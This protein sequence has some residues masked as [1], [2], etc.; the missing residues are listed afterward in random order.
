MATAQDTV[1]GEALKRYRLAAGL[2]QEELAERSQMSVRGLVYLERGERHPHR[3]TVQRLAA[4]LRL[5]PEARAAFLAAA[6][7]APGRTRGAAIDV[8]AA[9]FVPFV[10]R[11]RELALVGRHLAGEGPPVLFVA[12][13]P[14][15]GKTRLLREAA[16]HAAAGVGRP[17]RELP[18]A[19]R[20]GAVCPAAG[21][22]GAP[23]PG[24]S[25]RAGARRVAGLRLAGAPP[26]R[27]G[28]RSH[29]TVAR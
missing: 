25:A 9:P 4:A 1:F 28:R 22:P 10:G 6:P 3:E 14:G 2:T 15:I 12:G 13:E 29:P 21:R 19:G 24:P 7:P 17:G 18:P 27:T 23:H 20:P 16:V 11:A 5:E 8:S 26:A